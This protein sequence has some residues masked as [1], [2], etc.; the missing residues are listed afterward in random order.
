MKLT[1]TFKVN[2]SLK[3]VINK[4]AFFCDEIIY[5][6][7]SLESERC[8][9]L[10]QTD[11]LFTWNTPREIMESEFSYLKN[12]KLI[13]LLSAGANHL[14]FHLIDKN[15]TLAS[16]VGAY[17]RPMAEHCIG[18]ILALAKSIVTRQL[19][20]KNNIFNNTNENRMIEGSTCG[21]IGF[22]GIGQEVANLIR[23]FGVKIYAINSSGK[24]DKEVSFIGTLKDISFILKE[25]DIVVLSI[26]YNKYTH[27]LI[28]K[29]KLSI[30]K[31]NAILINLA[32]GDIIVENDIYYHL[33]NNPDFLFGTDTWW[34]EPFSHGRFEIH[35]PFFDLPNFLG[36]PHNSA[37]V[38]DVMENAAIFALSNIQ[39][40]VENRP[41]KGL[42]KRED[43]N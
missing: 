13:Q 37:V 4:H 20:L 8:N 31:P 6:A 27:N 38:K 25:S 34:V 16:N 33:K 2:D 18:M 19:E 14:P 30:M 3:D 32:R 21:I 1:V 26:P 28:D 41:L 36:S 40:F 17:A 43:Y 22:G 29:E 10:S 15:I 42:I 35:Y 5:L 9:L 23:A 11:I 39:N 12:C 24:T 7:E